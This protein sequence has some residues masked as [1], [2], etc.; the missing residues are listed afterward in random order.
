MVDS[1]AKRHHSRVLAAL[2]A[3]KRAPG[4]LM[5]GATLYEVQMAEL[6]GDR[7]HLKQVQS[8]EG[9][10]E[11]K[12]QLLP[13]YDPY[14]DGVLQAD[15]GAV[16]E[17][18]T[19]AMVWHIDAG[20][21]DRGLQLAAY[22]LKHGLAMPDRFKRTTGCLV[23]EEVAE[24]AF[25]VQRSGELFD[26][27]VVARAIELTAEQDMPD[28]VRAKLLLVQGRG[29][30]ATV[31]DADAPEVRPIVAQ[32]VASLRRA[33]DLDSNCGGKKDLERAERV[34]KKFGAESAGSTTPEDE[35]A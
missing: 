17:I 9:K 18:V 29:L 30:M 19:N 15:T 20:S 11:L 8:E 5:A 35:G 25:K 26:L 16:D 27:E 1:P 12:R 14:L 21:F 34:L 2:E 7:L 31:G 24:A 13:K 33:I 28:E 4:Q 10:A 22:V 23:A 32:A 6:H 3:E